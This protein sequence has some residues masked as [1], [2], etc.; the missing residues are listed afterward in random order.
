MKLRTTL[1]LAVTALAIGVPAA[2][3]AAEPDG[4]Q[5]QL[6]L[7]AQP[8]PFDRYNLAEEQSDVST[9]A[10]GAA[11]HPDSR[12]DRSWPGVGEQTPVD[13]RDWSTVALG[14]VGGAFAMLLA[15]VGASAIRERRRLVLH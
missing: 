12:A 4:Y 13:D 10:T 3:A 15:I 8:E 9:R 2:T 7:G 1:A 5:P 14:A 11:G 6:Q